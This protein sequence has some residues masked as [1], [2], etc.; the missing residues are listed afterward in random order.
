MNNY[1]IEPLS[2]HHNRKDFDCGEEALNQYLLAVASQHAKKSVSRTFVLIEVDRPEK[3]LGFVT[4]TAC[5]IRAEFLPDPYPKKFPSKVSGAKIG[6][7][8]IDK[9][10]QQKGFGSQLMV[11]AM[12]QALI[13]HGS[14]GLVGMMVDAKNDEAKAYY[15]H[16]GFIPLPDNS[17]TLF[18]PIKTIQEAVED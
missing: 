8:A 12:S 11:F 14:I 6:R 16:Y 1:K 5:E 13:V 17:L 10:H 4:L 7:L 18:L 9:A 2:K 15:R 3:I